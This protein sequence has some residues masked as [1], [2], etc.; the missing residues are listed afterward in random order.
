MAAR[1]LG[2]VA[3]GRGRVV[4]PGWLGAVLRAVA[5][6]PP[7]VADRLAR[8]VRFRVVPGR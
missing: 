1:L 7:E 4:F 6:L 3:R 8:L 2:A 5:L